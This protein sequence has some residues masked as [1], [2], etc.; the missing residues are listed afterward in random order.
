MFFCTMK[1][2]A[3][4]TLCLAAFA[5]PAKADN[6]QHAITTI[7]QAWTGPARQN[8]RLNDG[9]AL[10]I[11][12]SNPLAGFVSVTFNAE[13]SLI[14]LQSSY[15]AVTIL[16]DDVV[17]PPSGFDAAFCSGRGTNTAG[18]LSRNS[19]TVN[20][21]LPAGVHSVKVFAQALTALVGS[22]LS[23]RLDDVTIL[24]ER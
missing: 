16:I 17:I 5:L 4:T 1:R 18:G 10:V 24:V 11:S 3:L 2:L 15:I 21:L 20:R 14:G 6:L 7:P 13:C 19:F 23:A 8:I 22:Q 9:G 12:F